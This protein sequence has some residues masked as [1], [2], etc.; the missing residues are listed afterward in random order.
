MVGDYRKLITALAF[1]ERRHPSCFAIFIYAIRVATPYKYDRA[2]VQIRAVSY[3][4]VS[5]I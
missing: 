3:V 1:R 5:Y 2:A 4:D